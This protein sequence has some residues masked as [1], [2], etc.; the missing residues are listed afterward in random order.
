MRFMVNRTE[1]VMADRKASQV[2]TRLSED[3]RAWVDRE[4]AA[5]GLNPSSFVRMTLKQARYDSEG[6]AYHGMEQVA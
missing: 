2:I 3:D 6:R 1:G 5:R 4:A